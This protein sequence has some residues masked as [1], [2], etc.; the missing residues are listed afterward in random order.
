MAEII[1]SKQLAVL[2]ESLKRQGKSIVLAGGCFD[3]L[4][5]GHVIFL[6]RAKKEG[7]YLFVLLESDQKAKELKGEDRPVY[8]Q[9]DRARILSA[10]RVVD[11][12]VLLPYMKFEKEYDELIAQI[13]PDVIAVTSKDESFHHQRSARSVGAKFKVV[14][15]MIGNYSTSKVLNHPN[16]N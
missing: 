12:V 11:C 4:H 6:E 1:S 10:L 3:I 7:D 9:Q 13:K 15:D 16:E 5:P 8:T 14:T 2:G